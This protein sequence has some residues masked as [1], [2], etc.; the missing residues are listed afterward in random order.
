MK[1]S[2]ICLVILFITLLIA[3]VS[4][5]LSDLLNV[6]LE[7]DTIHW[8]IFEGAN[9]YVFSIDN[10]T[11]TTKGTTIS[12]FS[13]FL[14]QYG[15][16]SGTYDISLYA[17]DSNEV[18]ISNTW[19]GTY[20]YTALNP[21]L[22]TPTN[23]SWNG[24]VA[25]WSAVS[26]A[27]SYYIVVSENYSNTVLRETITTNSYDLSSDVD[28]T[29]G[30]TYSF[31]V[32]ACGEG[33]PSSE[34]SDW[35][36]MFYSDPSNTIGDIPNVSIS[37][38]V[39][40]WGKYGRSNRF[41]VKVGNGTF[42]RPGFYTINLNDAC[43]Y[44]GF[45]TGDY[46]VKLYAVEN[47]DTTV[48]SNVW[49]GSYHYVNNNPQLSAPT[50]VRWDGTKARWDAVTGAT[51]YELYLFKNKEA[52]NFYYKDDITNTYLDL[53]ELGQLDNTNRFRFFVVA[54]SDT[55]PT[56]ED[57]EF[58]AYYLNGVV[59]GKITFRG[60]SA[61]IVSW[62]SYEGANDY[63]CFVDSQEFRTNGETSFN[64]FDF[65]SDDATSARVKITAYNNTTVLTD[66]YEVLIRFNSNMKGDL[67]NDKSITIVDVRLL[68]QN[69]INAGGNTS[70]SSTD[71]SIM[72]MDEDNKIN[73]I[74]V[75][76]L[77]QQYINNN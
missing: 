30:N 48:V 6:E 36:H 55:N 53:G 22:S 25:S 20:T 66:T 8:E 7:G 21:Q 2:K 38:D 54:K 61:G 35:C 52:S 33:Y 58:S 13:N 37:G 59:L 32:K 71:L 40:S 28:F 42:S 1:K 39:L 5:A 45:V 34:Y 70:W 72:D 68:L 19:T 69:Y 17:V 16:S 51:K 73:I 14:D 23:L 31:Y 3:N 44:F 76:L 77:L 41:I 49:E 12:G 15:F 46:T 67:D 24:L 50:N 43:L 4:F 65:V 56:S 74:D 9:E 47:D 27:T 57:S 64:L 11:L 10:L 75:R 62:D 18:P 29:Y 63:V 60:M 26:N